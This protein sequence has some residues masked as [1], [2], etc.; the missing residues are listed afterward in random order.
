MTSRAAKSTP[1]KSK[2]AE[3][4]PM[5]RKPARRK[6]AKPKPSELVR[7]TYRV[8]F[9]ERDLSDAATSR[10]WNDQTTDH[11]LA[12]GKS[13]V[14]KQ[15]LTAWFRELLTAVPDWRIEIENTFDDGD[16]QAVVQWRGTGTFT[17]G[18]FLG[19][20]PNGRRVE[21]RG[22][23]LFRF[24]ADGMVAENTVYYD[25]AEFA[26]QLGMLPA[27]DSAADRMTLAAF[28]ARTRV[29]QAIKRRRGAKRA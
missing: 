15:A 11:F 18:P 8:L 27:R 17:G 9:E 19:M 16:H 5:Q 20:E 1:A 21:I 25:G 2:P 13:V 12:A 24:D 3:G 26:R 22:V 23:D 29:A 4:K 14:G 28:N 7:E 6:P 10:F